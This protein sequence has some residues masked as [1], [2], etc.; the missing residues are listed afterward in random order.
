[1]RPGQH[2]TP[3]FGTLLLLMLCMVV[4]GC[5][6]IHGRPGP[7]PEVS[8]PEDVVDFHTLYK[9]NCAACH[10]VSGRGGAAMELANPVYLSYAGEQ[11]IA[12]V[13]ATGVPGRLMPS[14]AKSSGGMLTDR[15]IS[16]VAQGIVEEWSKAA[17]MADRPM[18]SYAGKL[19]GDIEH[20]QQAFLGSC[21]KCHGAT[22]EG[23]SR[24]SAEE[25][26]YLGSIVDPTYLALVSDQYLRGIAVAGLPDQ[27]MP[28]CR[29]DSAQPL[30][31]QEVTDIVAW[32][33]SKRV[34]NPGQPY[35]S[36]P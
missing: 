1:M 7:G 3:L 15:Q 17:P 28:D 35:P 14:F 20:G 13:V 6:H 5:D 10:G 23:S 8:R 16:V 21:A 32:L 29:N 30:T 12:R 9:Q 33:A 24:D 26:R 2:A 36:H 4:A 25:H 18:P 19:T 11:N 27:G 31:D 22:G 34:A